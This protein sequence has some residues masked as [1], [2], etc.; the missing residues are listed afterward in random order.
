MKPV[1]DWFD[2]TF[3]LESSMKKVTG[4]HYYQWRDLIKPGMVFLTNINGVGSNLINPSELKHGAIYFGKG[5]KTSINAAID[6]I[7]REYEETKD[8][9]ELERLDRLHKFLLEN[10][11][12]DEICYVI[13][14]VGKGVVATNLVK[15]MTT[16]DRLLIIEPTYCGPREMLLASR[17]ALYWLGLPYD[18]GFN[19]DET[20][21]YCFEVVA[22]AYEKSVPD[23]KLK[24]QVWSV[25]G[26][27]LYDTFM[28]ET[29]L[30]KS[31][32]KVLIDSETQDK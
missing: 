29:F 15:F 9:S 21:K 7:N 26:N 2:K 32:F 25:L 11:I 30:D 18:Y 20:A 28:G 3:T 6:I 16:K 10:K 12:D 5:L 31:K 4:D 22:D 19:H 24:R 17:T 13:E 14:A 23:V 1:V 27:R 8:T